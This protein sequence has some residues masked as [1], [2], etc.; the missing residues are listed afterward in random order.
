MTRDA[1]AKNSHQKV[2]KL[3]QNEQHKNALKWNEMS[4]AYI[5]LIL[6]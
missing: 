4:W 6:D 5:E 1:T 2:R 3:L